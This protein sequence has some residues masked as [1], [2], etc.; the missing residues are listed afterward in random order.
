MRPAR[1]QKGFTLIELMLVLGIIGILASVAVPA[2]LNGLYRA[3]ASER[4]AAVKTIKRALDDFFLVKGGLPP[5]YGGTLEGAPTPALPPSAMKR[6]PDFVQPG[7]KDIF[8][9]AQGVGPELQG[10][11][12]YSYHFVV[13]QD[14]PDHLILDIT[15]TGDVDGDTNPSVR[16]V[17]YEW[18]NGGF[19]TRDVWQS[20]PGWLAQDVDDGIW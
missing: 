15:A 11:L 3:R 5:E 8:G 14:A 9:V 18:Q 19:I 16:S 7:W 6:V 13:V 4:V 1:A 17:H 2:F 10:A 12:Y 20:P